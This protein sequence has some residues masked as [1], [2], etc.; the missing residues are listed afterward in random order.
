[1]SSGKVTR[2]QREEV[3]AAEKNL[4]FSGRS[5]AK[6][7]QTQIMSNPGYEFSGSVQR[8]PNPQLMNCR[9]VS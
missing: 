4:C 9:V 6:S 7:G 5:L 8:A 1:M 3:L 2:V